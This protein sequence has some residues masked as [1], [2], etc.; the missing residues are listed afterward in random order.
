MSNGP[1]FFIFGPTGASK[2]N[3]V[4]RI[5]EH[6]SEKVVNMDVGQFYTPLS[7]GTA[8]PEKILSILK[9]RKSYHLVKKIY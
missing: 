1:M 7:I 2:T 4:L 5:A 8:K 3:L 9:Y 6:I